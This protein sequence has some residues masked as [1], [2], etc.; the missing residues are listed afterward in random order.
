MVNPRKVYP[1]NLGLIPVFDRSGKANLG[2]ALETCVLLE[3]ERRGTAVSYVRTAGGLEVDFLAR[4][5][6]GG[7]ELIQVCSDLETPATRAREVR[8]LLAAAAEHPRAALHLI[9]LEP[10][11]AP[12]LPAAVA[13]HCASAWLLGRERR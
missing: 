2:H 8:A 5:P 6:N 9:A 10:E 13:F 11:A 7:E 4:S 3:L 1:I 12:E